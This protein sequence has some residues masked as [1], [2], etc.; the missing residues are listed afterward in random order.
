MVEIVVVAIVL[1]LLGLVQPFVFQTIIDR[2]LPFQREATLVLIVVI[3]ALTT[4]FSAGLDALAA[5]L[6]NHMSNRLTAELA[7]RIFRHVLNLPLRYLQQWQVGET[8]A[9]IQEIDTVRGFLTGTVS[10]IALD[11]LFAVI[12]IGALL[13]I[14]PF[15][16]L[17]VL[18]MLPLQI[19]VFG[20]IGPFVRRRM[21]ESF[22]AGSHHQ[23]R[24]VEAFANAAT[25]KAL[26]S[27][28]V[29]VERFQETLNTSLLAG[30]RV[31]KLNILNSFV[32]DL[33][34]NGSVI[35]IIFFGSRLVFQNEITLGE[36]IAF[37][38]LAEKVSG[39]ILS[40]SSIWEQW[41]GLR[42]ARLRLGDFLNTPA[43]T[44]TPRPKLLIEGPLHLSLKGLSFGYLPDQ[45][46]IRDM[47]L[48]IGPNR[49]TIIVG[50]SGRGKSTLA[51][52]MSGLYEPDDGYVEANGHK[53][54]DCDPRSVRHS[55]AY[56]PQ[57]PALF[58]GSIMD[59]LLLAKPD[60]TNEEINKALADSAS[61]RFIAQLPDGIHTDVGERGAF[62][63][64][65]QRQRVA[66]ARS[67]LAGP[68][69]LILD[70]PTSALDAQSA[71][72]VVET[73]KRLAREKT[74]IVI[75]HNPSLLGKDANVIDLDRPEFYRRLGLA[76]RVPA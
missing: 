19:V 59:N 22:L 38:L 10:G 65:G 15:L 26:T 4:L 33:L 17:I 43:E 23:S 56:L 28:G 46:V 70:E 6:G 73:L 35:L 14:S 13:S 8:L 31:A 49:S 2:V 76:E 64:G 16:T 11:I 68:A 41:Q 30:F 24:L 67:L 9:R 7:H 71:G 29:Q 40:L 53:L 34:C 48:D 58:S 32:G 36:L 69:A 72:V 18:V 25:V 75:T 42:V 63:S 52:L 55:I 3:L 57:E 27:E 12:Y 21:Q 1:R 39:P 45:A 20:L 51:K 54:A 74:L 37:H 66:L 61:D 60:A 47:T 5:F 44:D 50:D 62:L